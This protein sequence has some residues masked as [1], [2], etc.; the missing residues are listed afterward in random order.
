MTARDALRQCIADTIDRLYDAGAVYAIS[1]AER[2]AIAAELLPIVA[3]ERAAAYRAAA[4]EIEAEQDAT[5]TAAIT[6]HDEPYDTEQAVQRAVA[7]ITTHL[8]ARA[9]Q[10]GQQ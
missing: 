4:D 1:D 9:D 8:R 2:D 3:A 6:D 5:D 7:T 10:M